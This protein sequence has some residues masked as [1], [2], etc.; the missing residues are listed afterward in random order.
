MIVVCF[1]LNHPRPC[2]A[3]PQRLRPSPR[4]LC[5]HCHGLHRRC[6]H[7]PLIAVCF[8]S[9]HPHRARHRRSRPCPRCR[10]LRLIVVL[11]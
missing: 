5:L 8:D 11:G 10:R 3:S 6:C 4:P 2:R 7:A 1:V 9:A